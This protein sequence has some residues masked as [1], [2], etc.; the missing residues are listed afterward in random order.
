VGATKQVR[1]KVKGRT[2]NIFKGRTLVEQ[3]TLDKGD[4]LIECFKVV[5]KDYKSKVVAKKK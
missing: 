5:S 2:M 4:D 3:V 1:A